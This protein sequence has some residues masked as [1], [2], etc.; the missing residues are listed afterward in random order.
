MDATNRIP[1]EQWALKRAMLLGSICLAVGL[2]AGWLIRGWESPLASTGQVTAAAQDQSSTAGSGAAASGANTAQLKQAADAQAA[3]LL[4]QLK[5]QPDN[6]ELL[7]SIGNLY[8]DGQ[9]YPTA[10]DYYGRALKV[11]PADASV[12]TDL[13]TAYWYMG[14]ADAAI[15]Q[16]DQALKDAPANSN[17]LFNR[18]LVKWEGKGDAVG[19]A[20]D[21]KM[22]LAVNPNY[23]EKD[24][25]Q[26]MLANVEKHSAF[27][28][29]KGQ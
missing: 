16:F 8:Y 24:K 14:N 22:L 25:V 2:A 11:K 1:A 19:A 4:Q 28:G 6:A 26:K 13:G 29:V 15:A 18:G 7:T 9:Q 27:S 20:A 3:P 10:I 12:R 23:A 5:S 21:W 17:T